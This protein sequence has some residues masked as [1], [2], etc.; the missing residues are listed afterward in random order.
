MLV[1]VL[2]RVS[3]SV[4]ARVSLMQ[5]SALVFVNPIPYQ[6]QGPAIRVPAEGSTSSIR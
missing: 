2:L 3:V 1:L 4:T 5:A 6:R